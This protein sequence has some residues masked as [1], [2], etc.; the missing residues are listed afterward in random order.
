MALELYKKS[1]KPISLEIAIT[2]KSGTAKR[3]SSTEEQIWNKITEEG[4]KG[5][6]LVKKILN[7]NP[8]KEDVVDK[9]VT[10]ALQDGRLEKVD[11]THVKVVKS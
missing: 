5:S 6:I 10:D 9:V 11:N 7:M 3:F 1:A 4:A 2:E 8:G